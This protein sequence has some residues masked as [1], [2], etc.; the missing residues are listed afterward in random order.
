[1]HPLWNRFRQFLVHGSVWSLAKLTEALH[2][3]NLLEALKLGNHKGATNDQSLL[4]KS[5]KTYVIHRYCLPIPLHGISKI[6]GA[7]LAPLNIMAQHT[8]DENG[9]IISK[10]RLT[11]DQSFAWPGSESS[12]NSLVDNSKLQQCMFV[13][14]SY[15]KQ[16]GQ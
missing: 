16:I 4:C 6:P 13:G 1:M 12:V 15:V 3:S 2:K 11:H 10:D 14:A 9:Q 5:V 8:I 7:I